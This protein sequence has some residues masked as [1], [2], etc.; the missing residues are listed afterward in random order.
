MW[1]YNNH[2]GS[3]LC[4]EIIGSSLL[5]QVSA[6]VFVSVF[7]LSI[8]SPAG[9]GLGGSIGGHG[10]GLVGGHGGA[11]VLVEAMEVAMLYTVLL[12]DMVGV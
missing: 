5:F 7:G 3:K 4:I 10:R 2:E 12:E 1:R 11:L 6:S 9:I 8:G